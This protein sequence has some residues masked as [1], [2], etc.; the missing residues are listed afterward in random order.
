MK[1]TKSP[2]RRQARAT[3]A[4][5]LLGGALGAAPAG[6]PSL[7]ELLQQLRSLSTISQRPCLSGEVRCGLHPAWLQQRLWP[8]PLAL[9]Q[10]TACLLGLAQAKVESP[11]QGQAGP[12]SR[13]PGRLQHWLQG[14]GPAMPPSASWLPH[15]W[16]G[17]RRGSQHAPKAGFAAPHRARRLQATH[18][19]H[20]GGLLR[21]TVDHGGSQ[22]GPRARPTVLLRAN[23]MQERTQADPGRSQHA[24]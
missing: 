3:P 16:V 2:C 21:A 14:V 6:G 8:P 12:P 4:R 5:H 19:S 17:L 11:A 23:R 9:L 22:H 15:A 20:K 1:H 10:L 7:R 24:I 13:R 18:E